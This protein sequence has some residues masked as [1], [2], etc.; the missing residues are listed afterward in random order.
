VINAHREGRRSRPSP[1]LGTAARALHSAA[2]LLCVLG[3]VQPVARAADGGGFRPVGDL[4]LRDTDRVIADDHAGRILVLGGGGVN[5]GD[6]YLRV[7]LYDA[8]RLTRIAAAEFPPY[9]PQVVQ[10][11]TPEVFAFDEDRRLLH[12]LVY[13]NRSDQ[14]SSSNPN[15]VA[16]NVDTLKVTSGPTPLTV[17]PHGVRVFGAAM[18]PSGRIG[19]VGQLVPRASAPQ[20]G[21]VSQRIFGVVVGE[22]DAKSTRTTWGP[23]V[24]RGCQTVISSQDQAAVAAHAGSVY[25][26]CGT[27]TIATATAPG[28]PA[29]VA[30]DR[31][32]PTTQRLN[33]LPGSYADGD[34]YL[35][36]VAGR[37]LLVGRAGDRPAQAVWVFDLAHEVYVG[38]IAA[39]D[40]TIRGFGVDP[41]LGRVYVSI[42]HIAE[43]GQVLVS[44]DLGVDIPQAL[45]F[46]VPA[47]SGPIVAIPSARSVIVPVALG[48]QK[49]AYRVFHDQIPATT[50]SA[51]TLFDYSSYD[52]LATDAPQFAGDVQA[53]GIRLHNVG[54]FGGIAKNVFYL[55]GFPYWPFARTGLKDGDRDLYLARV[56]AAHLSQDEAS[57]GAIA[58]D[59]DDT[60]DSDYRTIAADS[61]KRL[62]KDWHWGRA[63]CR[64]F[65]LGSPP[66]SADG[67]A[68]DCN[69]RA[70]KLDASVTYNAIPG[71]LVF[72]GSASSTAH[73]HLDPKLGLVA[74]ATAEA[75]HIAIAG[76]VHIERITSTITVTARGVAGSATVQ[77][78]SSIEGV[79]AG[80]FTCTAR[81]DPLAVAR[82]IA[83]AL[84]AQFRVELPKA[85]L[86]KTKGGSH[87][88]ALREAWG[89]Q[90]DVV[91]SSQDPTE[92]QIPALRLIY[93]GDNAVASRMI[94]EFAGAMGDA[95][96][97]RVAPG[98]DSGGGPS[99]APPPIVPSVLPTTVSR[100]R[101]S[102]SPPAGDSIIRRIVRGFR[103]GWH[104]SFDMG[105]RSAAL[106][107]ILLLPAFLFARRRQ[108]VG[109]VRGDR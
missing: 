11:T 10:S 47:D 18:W 93:S 59:R 90:Q 53:F 64:D 6:V 34:S 71:G 91:L 72:V 106:W 94:I 73:I 28:T 74:E 81:C 23:V 51:S 75:R 1:N 95:T 63:E 82:A 25:V 101:V 13:R 87:A 96:F 9:L 67:A 32:S 98:S 66:G 26:A 37:L 78:A 41:Q 105:A 29:V 79:R 89:H 42:G 38:E 27:G 17:F 22:V 65:G 69:E 62:P 55:D 84:G 21:E 16:V 46:D 7:T 108:L 58:V 49:I 86:F 104:V 35:D 43:P 60:T 52:S 45:A 109:L 100:A 50:F 48:D 44:S 24:V 80:R 68:V 99:I 61:H 31:A 54:G 83:S 97:L 88:H 20:A 70:A 57:A 12:V 15:L 14:Q 33:V 3:L 103:H 102:T 5:V 19:L 30:I 76:V 85:D 40:F 2:V 92:L 77:Y 39:G 107:L 4:P 56:G 36:P 8:R